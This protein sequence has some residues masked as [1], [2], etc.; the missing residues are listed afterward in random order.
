MEPTLWSG[1]LVLVDHNRNFIDPQGGIYAI[2]MDDIIMIK[3]VQVIY[4]SNALKI[5]SDNSRYEPLEADTDKVKIN[6]KII[7]FG[8]EI[9]R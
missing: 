4:P 7:W 1:D 9:E 6:G 8:R 3:R 5:L 2:A